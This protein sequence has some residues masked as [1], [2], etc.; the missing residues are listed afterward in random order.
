MFIKKGKDT[1]L[2]F[3]LPTIIIKPYQTNSWV[4]AK[5]IVLLGFLHYYVRFELIQIKRKIDYTIDQEIMERLNTV[6]N[7]QGFFISEPNKMQSFLKANSNLILLLRNGDIH[8][9][10]FQD[11]MI[12]L[13]Q[14]EPFVKKGNQT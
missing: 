8:H 13:L 7:T 10:Y 1:Q 4:S 9:P 5:K 2:F 14:F 6:L 3:C 12:N 11:T